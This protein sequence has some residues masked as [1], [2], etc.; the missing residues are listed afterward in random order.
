[1]FGYPAAFVGGNMFAGLHEHRLV[2]RLDEDAAAEAKDQGAT[3]FEPLPGRRMAGWVAL[4]GKPL[5]DE[6][7][8]RK[9][10]ARAFAHASTM[11]AK[12][13]KRAARKR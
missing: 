8:M 1:M 11:P 10:L 13:R 7:R 5:A 12:A 4:A 2:L 3:D 6:A 9:W